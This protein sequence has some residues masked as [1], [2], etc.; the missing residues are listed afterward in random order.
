V[1]ILLVENDDICARALRNTLDDSFDLQEA[2]TLAA[3][4]DYLRTTDSPPDLIITDLNLPDSKGAGTAESL[5][6]A[7][8]GTPLVVGTGMLTDGLR[9][10]I[11]SL[12]AMQAWSTRR[13]GRP[14][15]ISMRDRELLKSGPRLPCAEFLDEI[16]SMARHAAESAVNQAVEHLAKRLGLGDDEGVRMAVRLARGWEAAKGRFLGAFTTGIASA[17][18]LALGAGLMALLDRGI[19]GG[20]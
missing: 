18:L 12:A 11:E 17:I 4:L 3:A 1:K 16:D 8:P 20:R 2:G 7:A 15:R 5:R 14:L 10:Q 19:Q 9:A 6:H 13:G